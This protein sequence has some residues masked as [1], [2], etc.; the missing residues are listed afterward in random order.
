MT[1]DSFNDF[2]ADASCLIVL[3]ISTV[4]AAVFVVPMAILRG[5][6]E[7]VRIAWLWPKGSES[8]EHLL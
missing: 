5:V 6:V 2:V 3:L 8:G 4:I 1:I 7:G